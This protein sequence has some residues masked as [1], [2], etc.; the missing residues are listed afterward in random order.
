M[1]DEDTRFF[2]SLHRDSVLQPPHLGRKCPTS[3]GDAVTVARPAWASLRKEGRAVARSPRKPS[4]SL[5]VIRDRQAAE[6]TCA[7]DLGNEQHS[8]RHETNGS[9][10]LERRRTGE[11]PN[12]PARC[13]D[14]HDGGGLKEEACGSAEIWDHPQLANGTKDT[15]GRKDRSEIERP[16]LQSA[17]V[18]APSKNSKRAHPNGYGREAPASIGVGRPSRGNAGCR[19][20]L[21]AGQ[22]RC[23]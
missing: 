18:T 13:G 21:S 23:S 3:S 8:E 16:H 7:Y 12:G 10:C 1:P 6:P 2:G 11:V 17:H 15:T 5:Q 14:H 20:P 22:R 19:R 9:S 4:E